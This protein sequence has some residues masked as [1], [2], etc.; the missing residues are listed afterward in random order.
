MLGIHLW[1]SISIS[2][3]ENCNHVVWQKSKNSNQM[4]ELKKIKFIILYCRNWYDAKIFSI[5]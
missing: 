2:V 3:K 5:A 1:V 4:L